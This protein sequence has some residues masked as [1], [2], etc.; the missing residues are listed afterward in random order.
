MLLISV[1]SSFYVVTIVYVF[2][3]LCAK[4]QVVITLGQ[5]IKLPFGN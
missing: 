1:H 5:Q 4:C 2:N 3:K